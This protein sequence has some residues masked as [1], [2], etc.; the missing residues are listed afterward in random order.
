MAIDN[1]FVDYLSQIRYKSEII[2]VMILI[3]RD[4]KQVN[5]SSSYK[6]EHKQSMCKICK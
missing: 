4:L 5:F 1:G 3:E 2:S 6:H